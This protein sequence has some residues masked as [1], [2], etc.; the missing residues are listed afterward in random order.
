[1]A[2]ALV[3]L[4]GHDGKQFIG[5]SVQLK[6]DPSVRWGG[7]EVG[8]IRI[9]GLSHIKRTRIVP[10]TISKGKKA[11]LKIE[12][13]EEAAG[14]APSGQTLEAGTEAASKGVAAYTEWKNAL[15]PE[16]KAT[17]AGHHAG[18]VRLAKKADESKEPEQEGFDEIP[19]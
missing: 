19:M 15:P 11:P 10:T 4:W 12:L 3:H 13:I 14:V 7:E 8:G 16:I 9:A 2:R 5:R 18:F 17:I 1:M 6:H